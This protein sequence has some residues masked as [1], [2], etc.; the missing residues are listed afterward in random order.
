MELTQVTAQAY[1]IN[2]NTNPVIPQ[3]LVGVNWNRF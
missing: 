3:N 1:G 2:N